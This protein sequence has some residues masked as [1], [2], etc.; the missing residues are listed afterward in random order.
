M[1]GTVKNKRGFETY[2]ASESYNDQWHQLNGADTD[3]QQVA[4]SLE[5][6][7]TEKGSN[8]DNYLT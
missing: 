5:Q 1:L 7:I 8:I 3:R 6:M 4:K 2:Q